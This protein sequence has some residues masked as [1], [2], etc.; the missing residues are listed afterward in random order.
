MPPIP[1]CCGHGSQAK[2]TLYNE[3]FIV[4]FI[5]YFTAIFLP[6]LDLVSQLSIYSFI[7]LLFFFFVYLRACMQAQHRHSWYSQ[8]SEKGGY[9]M[10]MSY[11]MEPRKKEQLLPLN[12]I[13][14]PTLRE[15]LSFWS[16]QRP[17][18]LLLQSMHSLPKLSCCFQMASLVLVLQGFPSTLPHPFTYLFL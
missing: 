3:L 14:S 1:V 13:S 17:F 18:I 10:V 7:H 9:W 2:I 5:F 6:G 16:Y 11:H 8:R 4:A 12:H 15:P